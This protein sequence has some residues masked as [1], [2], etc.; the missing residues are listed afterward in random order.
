MT[1]DIER[2]AGL[3]TSE[4]DKVAFASSAGG[5]S[6]KSTQGG[7]LPCGQPQDRRRRFG[8]THPASG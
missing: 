2:G 5:R 4:T 6:W 8:R 3:T 7:F 1:L